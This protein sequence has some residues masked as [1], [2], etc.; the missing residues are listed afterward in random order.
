MAKAAVMPRD[1]AADGSR[2]SK[3]AGAQLLAHFQTDK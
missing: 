1:G 3:L 2:V